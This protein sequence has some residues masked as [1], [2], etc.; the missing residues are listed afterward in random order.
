[1]HDQR[2]DIEKALGEPAIWGAASTADAR[3]ASRSI[4]Q[5]SL[6]TPA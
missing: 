5:S 4:D 6:P 1:L 3:P 2:E